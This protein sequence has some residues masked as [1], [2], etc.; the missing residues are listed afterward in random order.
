MA[1]QEEKK[2]ISSMFVSCAYSNQKTQSGHAVV[3]LA[4]FKYIKSFYYNDML[5][6]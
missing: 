1:M 2:V 3:P 5:K 6:R 4:A